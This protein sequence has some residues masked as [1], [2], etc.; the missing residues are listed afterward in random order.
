MSVSGISARRKCSVSKLPNKKTTSHMWL[1]ALKISLL[2]PKGRHTNIFKLTHTILTCI[3]MRGVY[4]W[5]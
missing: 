5:G 2:R 3:K 4:L 1:R